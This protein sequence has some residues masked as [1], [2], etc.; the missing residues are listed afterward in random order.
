MRRRDHDS[1]PREKRTYSR[2]RNW[3]EQKAHFLKPWIAT[4]R[5][6]GNPIRR[7]VHCPRIER[8][9]AAG[10]RPDLRASVA[11]QLLHIA[12]KLPNQMFWL[13]R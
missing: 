6:F 9:V 4:L 13:F 12:R 2:K 5:G 3:Q 10:I 11:V 1:P 7:C 8:G